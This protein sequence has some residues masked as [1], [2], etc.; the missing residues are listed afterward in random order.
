MTDFMET[1]ENMFKYQ[2]VDIFCEDECQA[3]EN[4]EKAFALEKKIVKTERGR[5]IVETKMI[6]QNDNEEER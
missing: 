5:E 6:K 2:D 1:L 3:Y 4:A